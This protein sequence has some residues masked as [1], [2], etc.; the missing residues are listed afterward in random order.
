VTYNE[1]RRK[2]EIYPQDKT[3]KGMHMI[4]VELDIKS[5]KS[6]NGLRILVKLPITYIDSHLK[7]FFSPPLKNKIK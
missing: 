7:P 5:M 6:F 1:R 4:L 2:I 3:D